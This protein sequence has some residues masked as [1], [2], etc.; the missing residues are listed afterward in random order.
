MLS[1]LCPN[2]INPYLDFSIDCS[3]NELLEKLKYAYDSICQ[4]VNNDTHRSLIFIMQVLND[5]SSLINLMNKHGEFLNQ[6]IECVGLYISSHSTVLR[7]HAVSSLI[8]PALMEIQLAMDIS[9]TSVFIDTLLLDDLM[10]YRLLISIFSKMHENDKTL[11]NKNHIVNKIINSLTED[12][13][14]LV[15]YVIWGAEIMFLLGE[16]KD[17]IPKEILNAVMKMK[18]KITYSPWITIQAKNHFW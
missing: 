3:F 4:P 14:K 18:C 10:E 17:T 12:R 2:R 16:K 15:Y 9:Q 6:I 7:R 13:L 11:Y 5:H 1:C 8:L